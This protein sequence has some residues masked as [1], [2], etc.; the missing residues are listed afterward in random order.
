MERISP[1][2][3]ACSWAVGPTAPALAFSV[4]AYAS[5]KAASAALERYRDDLSLAGE[6]APWR[7]KL[8]RGAWS[9]I[10]GLGDDAVWSDINGALM[11]RVG[12]LNLQF[13]RPADKAGQL[14]AAQAVTKRR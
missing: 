11:V 1:S 6:T 2:L 10:V 14:K 5:D 8:P 12:R 9:D 3:A 4:E 13:T 7:G